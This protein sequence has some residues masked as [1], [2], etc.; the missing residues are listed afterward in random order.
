MTMA[1]G[2]KSSAREPRGPERERVRYRT[3]PTTTG[4]NPKKAL[5]KTTIERRPRNGKIAR[6]VPMGKLIT[7]ATAV[8][9]KLTPIESA[10]I[11]AKFCNLPMMVMTLGRS[12]RTCG[13]SC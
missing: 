13:A 7:V 9:A 12:I 11:S 1:A 8:A 10:T 2:V 3:R 6:A 4:G 5:T